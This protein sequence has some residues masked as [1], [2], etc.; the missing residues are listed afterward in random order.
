[1]ILTK[2]QISRLIIYFV[3][4]TSL[5]CILISIILLLIFKLIP[6]TN[7]ND[8]SNQHSHENFF[9]FVLKF[10]L[11][12]GL[13]IGVTSYVFLL[14]AVRL[15]PDFFTAYTRLLSGFLFGMSL[16]VLFLPA[17]NHTWFP[18]SKHEPILKD[19]EI[20]SLFCFIISIFVLIKL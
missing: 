15:Y 16:V 6:M 10:G 18:K 11:I 2:E 13:I 3:F 1:M 12:S 8:H 14:V 4:F 5:L 19:T 17:F 9:A 20:L 7:S